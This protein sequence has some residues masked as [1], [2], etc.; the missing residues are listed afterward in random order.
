MKVGAPLFALFA[1]GGRDAA[2]SA[3]LTPLKS[4][5]A[6]SILPALAANARAGH[7]QFYAGNEIMNASPGHP[8]GELNRKGWASP[9]QG[10]A[11]P[12]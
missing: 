8:S 9:R 5:G 1:K 11:S 7:P 2:R 10:W 12:P 3:D 6:D 4:H